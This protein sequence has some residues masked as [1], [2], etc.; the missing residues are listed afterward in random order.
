MSVVA[1]GLATSGAVV[2]ALAAVADGA[3]LAESPTA[4]TAALDR[5]TSE[6]LSLAPT[7]G[8]SRTLSAREQAH[9]ALAFLR[10]LGHVAAGSGLAVALDLADEP[11]LGRVLALLGLGLATVLVSETLAR[12]VGDVLGDEAAERLAGVTRSWW[13][14]LWPRQEAWSSWRR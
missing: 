10:V 4:G 1:W 9:R 12:M 7:P 8:V 2:A 5:P 6:R 3:L 14:R 11:A 13:H